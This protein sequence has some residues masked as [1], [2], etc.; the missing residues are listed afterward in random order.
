MIDKSGLTAFASPEQLTSFSSL[1]ARET[2]PVVLAKTYTIPMPATALGITSTRSGISG[3]QLLLATLDGKIQAIPRKM[4]EPRRPLGQVK[5][6]EKKE[7]LVQYHELIQTVSY[8]TLSH[9]QTV[10]GVQSIITTPTDVESQT[11]LLAYGGP[12]IFYA[13]TAPSKAFDLLPDNFNRVL[14]S[15]VVAG[16]VVAL[17]TLRHLV[18]KKVVKQG[19][20]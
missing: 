9:N 15:I 3:R 2:K 11:L 14:L 7:G 8:M 5:E 4:L 16:L 13:R 10:E 6:S 18:S 17:V 19:W 12:D 1:N 20:I